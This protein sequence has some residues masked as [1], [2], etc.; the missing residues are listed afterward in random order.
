MNSEAIM[1]WLNSAQ[2]TLM[3]VSESSTVTERH[4][5]YNF[6]SSKFNHATHI[7]LIST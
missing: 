2:L 4:R 7:S 5:F 3:T 1:C 6:I